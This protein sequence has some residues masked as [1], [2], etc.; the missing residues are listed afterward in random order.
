MSGGLA[1]A[2]LGPMPVTP[3]TTATVTTPTMAVVVAPGVGV[4]VPRSTT[5]PRTSSI[6]SRSNLVREW[7]DGI[8]AGGGVRQPTAQ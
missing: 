6:G 8:T 7:T 5:T 1:R 3:A 4:V 2:A